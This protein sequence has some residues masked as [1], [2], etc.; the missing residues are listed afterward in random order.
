MYVTTPIYEINGD[1]VFGQRVPEIP[2]DDTDRLYQVTQPNSGRLDLIAKEMYGTEELWWVI[3]DA[4]LM[5]DPMT[6]ATTGSK[7]RIPLQSRINQILR[8]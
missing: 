4:N 1:Y 5:T 2:Q 6:E 3:C 8:V 7:I